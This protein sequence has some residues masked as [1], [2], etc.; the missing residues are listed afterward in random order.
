[1]KNGMIALKEWASVCKALEEGKQILLLRKG[2]IM[3]FRK[4]FEMK[5]NEFFL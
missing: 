5:H 4:G 2:G 1:M 3:E